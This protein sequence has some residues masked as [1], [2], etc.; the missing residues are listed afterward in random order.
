MSV[1]HYVTD[2][3]RIPRQGNVIIAPNGVE[4]GEVLSGGYSPLLSKAIGSA[5]LDNKKLSS[6]GMADWKVLLRKNA[7]ALD[8]GPPALKRYSTQKLTE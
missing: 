7:L 8:I 5:L 2:D 1:V 4:S 3:R 6:L